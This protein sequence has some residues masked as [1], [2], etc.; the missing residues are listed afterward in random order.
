MNS[1]D[2]KQNLLYF[3]GDS[4]SALYESLNAWQAQNRK[5]FHSL[6]IQPDSGGFSCI[7]LTNPTEVVIVARTSE[8]NEYKQICRD[9][10]TNSLLVTVV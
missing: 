4:M 7:A 5:R 10:Y 8:D 9:H 1:D 6:S 2:N 3:H